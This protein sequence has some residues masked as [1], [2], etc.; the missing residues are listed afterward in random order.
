M[1]KH[2]FS[3][4]CD[5]LEVRLFNL[6]EIQIWEDFAHSQIV[7]ASDLMQCPIDMLLIRS[8]VLQGDQYLLEYYE[9]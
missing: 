5:I 9:N 4:I 1:T 7:P 2:H 3:L 6:I 8:V